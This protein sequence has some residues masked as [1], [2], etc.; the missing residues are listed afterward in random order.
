MVRTR[1]EAE[2]VKLR[3]KYADGRT[4]IAKAVRAGVVKVPKRE[5]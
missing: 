2:L 5:R 4:E 1:S 3:G